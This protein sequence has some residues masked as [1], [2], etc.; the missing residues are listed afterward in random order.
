MIVKTDAIV[1]RVRKYRE[2]SSIAVVYTKEFGKLSV[3]GKGA[4]GPRNKFGSSL[5]PL[6]HVSAVL[7]KHEGRDLHLISQCESIGRFPRLA[8]DLDKFSAAMSVVELLEHVAHGEQRNDQMFDLTLGVLQAIDN[9]SGNAINLQFFFELHLSDLLGF[10]PNFHTC[11]SC[12]QPLDRER[13]GTKGGE[14]RLLNGGIVCPHC[15]KRTGSEGMVSPGALSIL[16]RF[17]ETKEPEKVTPVRLTVH[18]T[19]EVGT[20]LRQYLQCHVG[21]LQHLKAQSVTESITEA[22]PE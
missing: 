5:Q 11:L 14:L 3:I 17:Q 20:I 22:H 12:D 18:Q 10:K 19:G 9:A 4:R 1:L 16:Q 8:Q 2:T 21:G 6:S 15:S 7:Y 13:L